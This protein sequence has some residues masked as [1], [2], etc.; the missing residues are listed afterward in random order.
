MISGS[1]LYILLLITLCIFA[2]QLLQTP[3][4]RRLNCANSGDR[5]QAI[6]H[7]WFRIL[8]RYKVYICTYI[9]MYTSM[10]IDTYVY[11]AVPYMHIYLYCVYSYMAK[12]SHLF[13]PYITLLLT[14]SHNSNGFLLAVAHSH[15]NAPGRLSSALALVHL[16]GFGLQFRADLLVAGFGSH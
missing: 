10:Y 1:I 15:N 11:L 5:S 2:V 7:H 8:Y 3:T 12:R 4:K 6:Y 14:S 13:S 9:H 16:S